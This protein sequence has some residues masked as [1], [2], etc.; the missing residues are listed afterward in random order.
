[1]QISGVGGSL[2][3]IEAAALS[4]GGRSI[5]ALP[6][7]TADGKHS[8]IVARLTAGAVVT[9]PRFCTDYVVT[10]YGV[11]RLKGQ[12]LRARAE[13]MIAIA[14]PQLRDSMAKSV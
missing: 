14:H 13:A 1:M 2:D 12:E 5:L 6:S 11:A 10:E 9:T 4:E 8:K 7:T 3:F